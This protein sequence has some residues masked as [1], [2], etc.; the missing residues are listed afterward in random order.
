MQWRLVYKNEVKELRTKLGSHVATISVLLMTQ[1]VS[2]I[3]TA[4]HDMAKVTCGLQRNILAHRKLLEDVK[5][6]V[7]SSLAR[8]LE[9]KLQLERQADAMST[10]DR[11]ADETIL[12]LH[13][14]HSLI[15]DVKSIALTTEGHTRSILAMATD[16]LSSDSRLVNA[17]RYCNPTL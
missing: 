8:Q 14:E 2:S 7:Y 5:T 10:L 12:Q 6:G 11:K 13:D 1:T 4:E 15:Q 9:T 17:T 16:S 3:T